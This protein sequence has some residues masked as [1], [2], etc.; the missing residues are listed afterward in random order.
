MTN[1]T[2]L[3]KQIAKALFSNPVWFNTCLLTPN[4]YSSYYHVFCDY[5]GLELITALLNQLGLMTNP[6][7]KNHNFSGGKIAW[8]GSLI[9]PNL[10]IRCLVGE[11]DQFVDK[12]VS[13]IQP[14]LN[15]EF[16]ITRVSKPSCI[17]THGGVTTL[18]I[19]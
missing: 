5:N 1:E 14:L 17:E 6:A 7:K 16:L 15:D 19:G 12:W 4:P 10:N 2:D 11:E 18:T 9:I 13:I 8:E 3:N